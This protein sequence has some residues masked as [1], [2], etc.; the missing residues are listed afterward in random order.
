[1]NYY[2][3]VALAVFEAVHRKLFYRDTSLIIHFF[4]LLFKCSS[5]SIRGSVEKAIL[6]R[7]LTN[8]YFLWI[9]I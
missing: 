9:I 3:N 1:L 4:E 7:Y 2:L 8:H 6:L 5:C